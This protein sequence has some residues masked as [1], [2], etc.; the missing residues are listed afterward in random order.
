MEKDLG[1]ELE[2]SVSS[3]WWFSRRYA[4]LLYIDIVFFLN[5][6][7][8]RHFL[9]SVIPQVRQG[10]NVKDEVFGVVDSGSGPARDQ[11]SGHGGS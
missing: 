10:G 5:A 7:G 8:M 4:F 11:G 2:V 9:L 3:Y 6:I 1:R